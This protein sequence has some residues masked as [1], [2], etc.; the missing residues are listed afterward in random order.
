MEYIFELKTVAVALTLVAINP[1]PA[2]LIVSQKSIS[3][4]RKIGLLTALGVVLTS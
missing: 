3:E 2:F 4:S 1:G